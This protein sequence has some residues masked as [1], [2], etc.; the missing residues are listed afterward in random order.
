MLW[1]A[2]VAWLAT[3]STARAQIDAR[4][5]PKAAPEGFQPTLQ[6][7]ASAFGTAGDGV[8]DDLGAIL[9]AAAASWTRLK[10]ESGRTIAGEVKL[11]TG[12]Y[13]ITGPLDLAPANGLVG[14][15]ISGVGVGTEIILDGPKATIRCLA[16]RGVTFRDITFKSARGVD[17]GQSAFTID[18][19]GNAL[20]SWRFE[21]CD[22]AAVYRCFRVQGHSMASEFFFDKCQFYQC[23][24]LMDNDNDQ[25]VNWNFVNCNWENNELSTKRDKS[26]SAAFLL[27]KGSFIKWTGGSLIFFGRLVLYNLSAPGLVQRTAHMV[28]FDGVRIELEDEGGD[29]VPFVDRIDANYVSG[30]NQPTIRFEHCTILHRGDIRPSPYYARAWANCSLTFTDCRAEGGRILGVLDGVTPTHTASISLIR[31]RSISYVEDVRAR[32]NTHDQHSVTIVPDHSSAGIEPIADGRLC[33]LATPVTMHPKYMYVRDSSGSLPVGGTT[34]ALIDLPDH[35]V[36]L[37]LFVRRFQPATH[38]LEIALCDQASIRTFSRATLAKGADRVAE[39]DIGLEM[40]YQIKSGTRLML[41]FTGTPEI[42][43]GIVGIEYL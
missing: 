42:V 1:R 34:V 27:R 36:L 5:A 24:H 31:C 25:A 14:L 9:R 4:H 6:I 30:T 12:R 22:F 15:T 35:T 10:D 8:A 11:P 28:A 40:G 7:D 41:K 32:L 17:D 33:N 21:R 39:A 16:S 38:P 13:R 23:Y 19:T 20:R 2:A 26:L 43:K 3:G 29:H 37:R 18:H